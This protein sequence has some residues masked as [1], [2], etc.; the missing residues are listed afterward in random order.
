M[1]S[2]IEAIKAAVDRLDTTECRGI[3]VNKQALAELR[4]LV[5]GAVADGQG[6]V[7]AE[8][9]D[10]IVP[11]PH[12][13]LW[14]GPELARLPV[15]TQLY[16]NPGEQP[17][18]VALRKDLANTDQLLQSA[19]RSIKNHRSALGAVQESDAEKTKLLNALIRRLGIDGVSAITGCSYTHPS[20]DLEEMIRNGFLLQELAEEFDITLKPA[21]AAVAE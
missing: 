12:Q 8:I 13:R 4:F 2:K 14:Y 3:V 1:S 17:D 7:A 10:Y 20:N 6:H 9:V 18:V 21:E 5:A 16:L 11:N 19:E 15:G